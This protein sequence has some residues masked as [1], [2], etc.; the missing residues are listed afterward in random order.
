VPDS[1][2]YLASEVVHVGRKSRVE[3]NRG[4]DF[5]RVGIGSRMIEKAGQIAQKWRENA[6]RQFVH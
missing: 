3:Q 2:A 6:D 4:I 1:L 5:S